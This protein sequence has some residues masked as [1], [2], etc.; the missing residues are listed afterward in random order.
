[1]TL[2]LQMIQVA[3]G[4]SK[5]FQWNFARESLDSRFSNKVREY[6]NGTHT[7]FGERYVQ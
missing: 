3:E 1:M 2:R 6:L 7:T 4:F 5:E